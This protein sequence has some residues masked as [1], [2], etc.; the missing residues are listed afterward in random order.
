[1]AETSHVAPEDDTV[2]HRDDEYDP[3]GFEILDRMQERHFWYRGRH[4][5]LLRRIAT[6]PGKAGRSG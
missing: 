3:A 5:F 2:A 4:R 1:M 6:S